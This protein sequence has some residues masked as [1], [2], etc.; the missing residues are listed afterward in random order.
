V[1]NKG[2][3]HRP[4]RRRNRVEQ[5]LRAI[6]TLCQLLLNVQKRAYLMPQLT[7][8]SST[9]SYSPSISVPHGSRAHVSQ[10]HLVISSC[11]PVPPGHT[12]HISQF[13]LIIQLTCLSSAWSYSSRIPVPHGHTAHVSHFHLVPQ[14]TYLA[15][16]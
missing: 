7:Y 5:N 16:S 12:A 1:W 3:Q 14:F 4:M 10:F 9:W 8:F 6:I 15:W 2:Q 11:I 13:H